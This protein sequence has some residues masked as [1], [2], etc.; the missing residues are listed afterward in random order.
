MQIPLIWQKRS[1]HIQTEYHSDHS[2]I[3]ELVESDQI[4]FSNL[5]RVS[6]PRVKY[7]WK[8]VNFGRWGLFVTYFVPTPYQIRE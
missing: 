3:V 2:I 7:F 5:D 4:R 1:E 6:W 8:N